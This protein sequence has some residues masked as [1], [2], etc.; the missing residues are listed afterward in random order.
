AH[1]VLMDQNQ[2][3]PQ[4]EQ[5]SFP[6]FYHE[7]GGVE[8]EFAE[9]VRKVLRERAEFDA[10]FVDTLFAET[11]GH[12]FLTVSVLISLVDWLIEERRKL[13]D[14]RLS[15]DDFEVFAKS[16]LKSATISL[17]EEYAFF[18]EAISEAI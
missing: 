16:N 6:L 3:S 2:L 17:K 14:L 10:G 4:V 7:P 1:Y 15:R 12:P 8:G 9:L 13:G 11:S 18:R 5:D